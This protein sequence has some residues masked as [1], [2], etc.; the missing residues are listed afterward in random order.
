MEDICHFKVYKADA[1]LENGNLTLRLFYPRN[2]EPINKR[3]DENLAFGV[4]VFERLLTEGYSEIANQDNPLKPSGAGSLYLFSDGGIVFHRRD[5][6]APTHKLYHGAYAGFPQT[7][8]SVYSSSGLEEIA[9]RESAEECLLVTRDKTPWLIVPNDSRQYVLE[10][11]KNLGL[12]LKPRFIDVELLQPTDKLEVYDEGESLIFSA[13]AFIEF[14]YESQTSLTS[15]QIRKIP[16]SSE[17]VFPIDAEGMIKDGKFIHFNRES[18]VINQRELDNQKFGS[19]LKSPNVCQ[20][21]IENGIPS[22]FAPDYPTPYLGPDKIEVQHPHVFAPEDLLNRC[23]DAIGVEGYGGRWI[24]LEL[25][26][27]KAKLEGRSLLPES[28]LVN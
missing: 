7:L 1:S 12:D 13:N 2:P 28:V 10:S 27:E 22:V 17:E 20:T 21:R 4:E 14:I 5:K 19:I 16:L 9:L 24:H 25:E 15:L 26:K 6:F 11:A 3:L 23:L 8:A 18:Y